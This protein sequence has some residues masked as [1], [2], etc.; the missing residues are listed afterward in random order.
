MNVSLGDPLYRPYAAWRSLGPSGK[1]SWQRYRDII[2]VADGNVTG[3]ADALEAAAKD[4]GNSMFL[5]AL[6]AAQ[7][8]AGDLPGALSTIEKALA[9]DNKPLVHFRLALEKLGILQAT[10]RLPE[11]RTLLAAE[12]N[13]APGPAQIAL[14][15]EITNRV[16]PPPPTPTPAPSPKK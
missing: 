5:E 7:A 2:L 3:A 11:V 6:G 15:N 10:K 1:S 13:R 12:R 16:F 8:D 9:M 4:S 14:L